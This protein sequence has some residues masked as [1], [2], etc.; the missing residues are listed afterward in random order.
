M[1]MDIKGI[2]FNTR[3]LVNSVQGKDGTYFS[4]SHAVSSL[5]NYSVIYTDIV[6]VSFVHVLPSVVFSKG[7]YTLNTIQGRPSNVCQSSNR[8]L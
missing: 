7:P 5:N 8:G 6:S 1:R 4:M 2:G 3:K